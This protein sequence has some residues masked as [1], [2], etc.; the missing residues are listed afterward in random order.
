MAYQI[1]RLLISLLA[2]A[3]ALGLIHSEIIQRGPWIGTAVGFGLV[4]FLQIFFNFPKKH[5]R[6]F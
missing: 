4:I 1:F 3:A 2:G 6:W 5:K